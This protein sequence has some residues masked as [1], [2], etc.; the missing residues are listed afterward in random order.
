MS[1]TKH[2]PEPWYANDKMIVGATPE[3]GQIGGCH[4]VTDTMRAVA[5]VNACK[6]MTGEYLIE[7]AELLAQRDRLLKAC[8]HLAAVAI[9]VK[10]IGDGESG[11]FMDNATQGIISDAI[12]EVEKSEQ[13]GG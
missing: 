4:D 3:D 7:H 5:C 9:P 11:W 13:Q 6:G 10:D 2:T 12:A 8:R 1:D